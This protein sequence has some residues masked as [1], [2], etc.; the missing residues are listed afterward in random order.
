MNTY[1]DLPKSGHDAKPAKSESSDTWH[2]VSLAGLAETLGFIEAPELC[3]I[4]ADMLQEIPPEKQNEL[5]SLYYE[6]AQKLTNELPKNEYR[7][8][9][10]AI[11]ILIADIR[12]KIGKQDDAINDI[13]EALVYAEQMSFDE[14]RK[15]LDS[16]LARVLADILWHYGEDYGFDIETVKE[17]SDLPFAEALHTTYSYL[18]SAGLDADEVLSAFFD[19]Q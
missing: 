2:Y 10:L 15:S 16:L 19:K 7:N 17:V 9:Q 3:V 13:S 18:V 8:A 14:A 1:D 4:K 11:M 6:T 5:L 12:R